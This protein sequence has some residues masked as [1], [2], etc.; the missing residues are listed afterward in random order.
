MTLME[1]VMAIVAGFSIVLS[2][3]TMVIEGTVY[4]ILSGVLQVIMGI[5]AYHQQTLI[6]TITNLK[7]KSIV[8]ESEIARLGADNTRLSYDVDELEGRVEDLLDVEDALQLV[9]KSR[10]I[11]ALERDADENLRKV[12]NLE[13]TIHASVIEIVISFIFCRQGNK[14]GTDSTTSEGMVFSEEDTS[15]MILKLDGIRGLSIDKNRLRS[16]VV[17]Q[18][19]ES[20]IDTV[21][22]L[23]DDDIPARNRI[24]HLK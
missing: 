2:L 11:D 19:I 5:Y 17:A 20:I 3:V 10:S 22:N 23:L 13:H 21:Q 4:V 9:S 24:F 12:C 15:K 18:P 8:F 7:E 1:Q 6:T 16:K 14:G